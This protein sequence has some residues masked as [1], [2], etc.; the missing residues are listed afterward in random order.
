[1]SLVA[2]KR[3]TP[4]ASDVP[5]ID[6][7]EASVSA[8]DFWPPILLRELRLAV[9]IT[10]SITTTRLMHVAIEAVIHVT[11]QLADL[12]QA[13]VSAGYPTLQAVL[14]PEVNGES[15][16]VHSYKNAV[17]AHSRA[18]L[19]ER[20][21]DV[22]TTPKGDKETDTFEKQV[23]DLWRDVRWSIADIRDEERLFAELC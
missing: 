10:G 16:K 23:D 4:A 13:Q 2:T 19:L 1:M 9:R 3:V 7:G 12:Q 6:D 22:D 15:V 5:D 21:R 14:A 8:G 18:A 17:Y 20:H 11:D